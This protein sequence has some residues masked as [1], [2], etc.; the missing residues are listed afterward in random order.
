[1]IHNY[2]QYVPQF[3]SKCQ[4]SNKQDFYC[5]ITNNYHTGREF[6]GFLINTNN[7]T[8]SQMLE[9][10]SLQTHISLHTN[11]G[12]SSLSGRLVSQDI[13]AI[14]YKAKQFIVVII[15]TVCFSSE[16]MKEISFVNVVAIPSVDTSS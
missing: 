15:I 4:K 11:N 7:S 3:V 6:I 2:H 9:F 1:M 10:R 5:L 14:N 12:G 16:S 8:I 13:S